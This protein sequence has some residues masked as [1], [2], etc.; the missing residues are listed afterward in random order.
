MGHPSLS[1]F[2]YAV[3][4]LL[5][6]IRA[7][8]LWTLLGWIEIRQ[9]YSR[10]KLG[11]LWLTISMAVMVG[12]LGVVYGAL[13]GQ[14]LNNYLP[15]VAVGLVIWVL[16]STIVNEGCLAYIV[17]A[18]YIRQ[19][20]TPRL[21]YIF[22]AVWRNCVIF[23]HNFVIV[24]VVL[25]VFGVKSWSVLIEF[26]PGVVLLVLNAMWIAVLV[27]LLSA[28]FRDLP[29]IV[30]ALMQVAFYI[31][32]ILFSGEMLRGKHHWI[33]DLNPLS[34]LID[35]VRQPLL[36]V[37]PP[38]LSWVICIGMALAGWI[39]ALAF[40]GRYHKRIPYWV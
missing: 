22:Q 5:E 3:E 6:S 24:V 37:A 11:P 7:W 17:S 38:D 35:V 36:G 12:T 2:G 14:A 26:I 40:T 30:S 28:R 23:A 27:G 10:S 39:L 21:L 13:F 32:P 18:N 1:S 20:R 8:R 33:V 34:Y 31:T 15:M 25:I 16:F 29:Q 19:V 4:D 9:R